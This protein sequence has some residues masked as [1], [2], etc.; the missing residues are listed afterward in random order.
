MCI[1]NLIIAPSKSQSASSKAES[2]F[3]G[4]YDPRSALQVAIVISFLSHRYKLVV[5]KASPKPLKVRLRW[6]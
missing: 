2:V 1:T 6:F 5:S 3:S 4:L